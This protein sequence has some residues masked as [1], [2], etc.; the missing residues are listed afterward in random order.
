[1]L[2]NGANHDGKRKGNEDGGKAPIV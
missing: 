1:L 2:P